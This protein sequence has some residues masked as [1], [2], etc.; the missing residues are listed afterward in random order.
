[1]I[2]PRAGAKM[3]AADNLVAGCMITILTEIRPEVRT[4][5]ET[6]LKSLLKDYE[7]ESYSIDA[8]E[9]DYGEEAIFVVLHYKLNERAFDSELQYAVR[10]DIS[11]KLIELGERRYAYVR[12]NL[13]DGQRIMH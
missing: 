11:R 4:A 10:S 9:D 6:T 5:I 7:L 2:G 3:E 8:G 12:H 13:H 1:L